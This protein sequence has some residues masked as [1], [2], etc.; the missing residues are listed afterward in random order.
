MKGKR[1]KL[2]KSNGIFYIFNG[3]FFTIVMFIILYPLYLV[4]IASVSDP[5]A[6]I[7]GEVIWHPVDFSLM[8][9][10]AVFQ[11]G[12]LLRSYANSIC[13]T[14]ISVMISIGVTMGAAYSLSRPKFPGKTF[15]NFM[16]VFTMF[17]GGGLIP[18]FLVMK[19]I[20]LYNNRW[21][22]ILM[23]C[24]SVWNLMVARTYINS[25]IPNELYEAAM[26]DGASHFDYFFKC[27]LPLSKTIVA[28]L[29]VYYGVSKWNDYFTGLVYLKDRKLLPLQTILREILATLQ[30]DKSGD[31]MLTMSENAASISDAIR[32]ANV[33]KYCIIVIA[34]VPVVFLYAFLQKYFEKGVMIGS[35]KG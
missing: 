2:S 33:A 26:L 8:G 17:F 16:F 10:K 25:N 35:L 12:E 20:G 15:F 34:T 31:Y 19:D 18:S 13:Y 23:G 28:V 6:I 9:Y 14:A 29:G 1:K 30:I 27:V 21:I 24:V 5:D 32:T 11:Y 3:I 4:I 22:M 7:R